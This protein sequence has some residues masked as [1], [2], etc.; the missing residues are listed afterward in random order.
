[1]WKR[2]EKMSFIEGKNGVKNWVKKQSNIM[3]SETQFCLMTHF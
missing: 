3:V 1:M 2:L